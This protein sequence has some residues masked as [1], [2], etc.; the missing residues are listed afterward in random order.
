M[1]LISLTNE[2]VLGYIGIPLDAELTGALEVIPL[3]AVQAAQEVERVAP[4][5]PEETKRLAALRLVAF[6]F[7][8]R[9]GNA[10]DAGR[11]TIASAMR[12]SGALAL[13]AP[14]RRI[15]GGVCA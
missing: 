1:A 6:N 11:I 4:N 8:Q 10:D 14:Y 3:L 9:A 13:L 5:A 12:H 7:A 15:S 2:Q